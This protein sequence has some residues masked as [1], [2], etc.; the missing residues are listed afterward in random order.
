MKKNMEMP[1]VINLSR[2]N[3]LIT[4]LKQ[5]NDSIFKRNNDDPYAMNTIHNNKNLPIS[6]NKHKNVKSLISLTNRSASITSGMDQNL[7]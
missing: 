5:P 7:G 3:A 1:S 6:F 4:P 2:T